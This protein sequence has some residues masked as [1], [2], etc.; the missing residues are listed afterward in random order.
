MFFVQQY[1]KNIFILISAV[2][3]LSETTHTHTPTSPWNRWWLIWFGFVTRLFIGRHEFICRPGHFVQKSQKWPPG[4]FRH[5]HWL[6]QHDRPVHIWR[7]RE[8]SWWWFLPGFPF[9]S[10]G[11][12]SVSSILVQVKLSLTFTSIRVH[13]EKKILAEPTK[14]EP[15]VPYPL[16]KWSTIGSQSKL[17]TTWQSLKSSWT[18]HPFLLLPTNLQ[19]FA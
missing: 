15:G 6:K 18:N 12:Y 11:N 7:E 19:A 9:W 3:H 13:W 17:L 8:K 14:C 5:F 10:Q 16:P 4:A 2:Q 1:W